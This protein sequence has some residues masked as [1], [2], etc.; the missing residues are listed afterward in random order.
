MEMAA[1]VWGLKKMPQVEI[2]E[3]W[4][5]HKVEWRLGRNIQRATS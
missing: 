2:L 3:L 1:S 4:S 5:H